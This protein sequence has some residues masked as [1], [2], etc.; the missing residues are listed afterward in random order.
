MKITVI[1]SG[2]AFSNKNFNQCFMLDDVQPCQPDRRMLVDCGFQTGAALFKAGVP[3]KSITDVYISHAHADHI[4]FLEGLAFQ[5]YDWLKKPKSCKD[6]G[7]MI[8]EEA[9]API[10]YANDKLMQDLWKHSLSGGLRS[11][12]GLDA[13]LETFFWTMPIESNKGFE[14]AL[15]DCQ[16]IQQI[17]IMTGSMIS[18]TFGLFMTRRSDKYKIYFTTDSQHCS[19]RQVEVYYNQ[20]DIIFQDCECIGVDT[21]SRKSKFVSGVHANY[22]QLAGWESANSVKLSKE[23]KAKMWLSHYQ[24]IVSDNIDYFGVPCDW[25]IMAK[26]DGFKGFVRVGQEILV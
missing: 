25:E 21:Q 20:A 12:E 11:I 26:D 18:N 2:A 17:H 6:D 1:G 22:A 24:D 10:L 16:L 4:G 23:I 19:P 5:R 9:Y 3:L 8:G 14:W 7:T 15:W 13:T